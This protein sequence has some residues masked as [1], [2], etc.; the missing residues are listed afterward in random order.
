MEDLKDK[1]DALEGVLDDIKDNTDDTNDK[2]DDIK[3][4]INQ[5]NKNTESCNEI[6]FNSN[7]LNNSVVGVLSNSPSSR[8]QVVSG[9]SGTYTSPF[10]KLGQNSTNVIRLNYS[11]NYFYYCLYKSDKTTAICYNYD[12]Q[13]Q[14]IRYVN[15]YDYLRFTFSISSNRETSLKRCSG[16]GQTL[17][18]YYNDEGID[19]SF[20][21]EGL[22]DI[23]N[24][25][26]NDPEIIQD[27]IQLP[28]KFLRTVYDN[29][30]SDS[31]IAYTVDVPFF[32]GNIYHWNFSCPNYNELIG[33]T[34]TTIIDAI[35]CFI[36]IF[37]IAKMGVRVYE[38]IS[39][40]KDTFDEIYKG[41]H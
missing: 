30:S 5:S 41:G 27:L 31:C 16:I 17:S 34:P 3:D 36:L 37:G 39:S 10:Y 40:A 33:E 23:T 24:L 19:D 25:I 29:V 12:S 9:D 6:T 2:L 32:D 8:G 28:V 4:G 20:V 15:D 18:D 38:D 22:Q 1:A 35:I 11:F 26:D 7:H 21:P 14:I 13:N